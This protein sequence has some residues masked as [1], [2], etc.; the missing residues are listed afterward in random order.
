V[1]SKTHPPAC[2][3][4]LVA[5]AGRIGIR[6]YQSGVLCCLAEVQARAGQAQEGL[7]TLAEALSVVEE[8]DEH[9]REAELWRVRAQLLPMQGDEAEAEASFHKAIEVARRQS[10]R[11]WE[12]RAATALARLWQAQGKIGEVRRMLAGIYR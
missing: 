12:L 2:V 1:G 11:S 5:C 6:C 3:G 7:S 10:A 8:T 9:H 4:D